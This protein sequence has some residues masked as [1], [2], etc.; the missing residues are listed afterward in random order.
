MPH[1]ERQPG[2][3][4]QGSFSMS[5]LFPAQGAGFRRLAGVLCLAAGAAALT[6][7]ANMYVDSTVKEVPATQFAKPA[8]P[9]PVQLL[10]EFQTKGT[11][12]TRATELLKAQVAEQVKGSGL[13][14][15][16]QNQAVPGGA[17]LNI[18]LN[19]VPLSDDAFAK[20]FVTGLTFG[21][22]GTQVGDGYVCTVNYLEDAQPTPVVKTA[23]HAIYTTMGA[24]SAPS[25]GVKAEN[26]EV[27]IRTVTRQVLS[28][29]LN[30]LSRDLAGK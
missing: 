13:F 6:G 22:A 5:P 3:D 30:D 2:H 29:T 10:F 14:S 17:L 26:A 11:V 9:K 21:L 4:T 28:N 7:C 18:T 24:T 25:N 23:R 15:D 8:S 16:V 20:G 27:A 12:N 1:P 19:N